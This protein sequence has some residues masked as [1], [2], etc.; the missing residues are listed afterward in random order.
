MNAR[1][2]PLDLEDRHAEPKTVPP[3]R[4]AKDMYSAPTRIGTLPEDILA[5]MRNE[6]DGRRTQSGSQPIVRLEPPPLP[7]NLGY[8]ELGYG[9]LGYEEEDESVE[10]EGLDGSFDDAPNDTPNYDAPP[11]EPPP[12]L[13]RTS[14]LPVG[15]AAP[16]SAAFSPPTLSQW[17]LP[18]SPLGL[19]PPTWQAPI[20]PTSWIAPPP[21]VP[22]P[23]A[24]PHSSIAWSLVTI[25]SFAVLGGLLAT[26]ISFW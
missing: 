26:A 7:S 1:T 22:I 17:A 8:E 3:P 11:Y 25:V 23:R 9:E 20:P 16:H 21:T 15:F 4:G 10:V 5:A 6:S 18:P 14:S 24:E 19:S 2:L 13:S 12:M